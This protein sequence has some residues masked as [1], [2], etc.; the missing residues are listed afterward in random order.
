MTPIDR[1][2]ELRDARDLVDQAEVASRKSKIGIPFLVV[3][4]VT[5]FLDIPNPWGVILWSALV[6]LG[7][8]IFYF[9]N[10]RADRLIARADVIVK[11]PWL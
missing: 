10:I 7:L 6:A 4:V 5:T 2:T 1:M 3:A 9:W 11:R 8:G